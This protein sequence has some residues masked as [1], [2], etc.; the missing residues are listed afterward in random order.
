M[1]EVQI[2]PHQDVEALPL[3][4]IRGKGDQ[5]Q[6]IHHVLR[7]HTGVK[8]EAHGRIAVHSDR[9]LSLLEL[10]PRPVRAFHPA[11]VTRVSGVVG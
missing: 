9:A 4:K 11:V 6:A 2:A 3:L 10:R 8:L 7:R 1:F 5:K